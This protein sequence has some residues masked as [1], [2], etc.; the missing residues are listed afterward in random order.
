MSAHLRRARPVHRKAAGKGVPFA[1]RRMFLKLAT[2]LGGGIA[3]GGSLLSLAAG[4]TAPPASLAA[5]PRTR[6]IVR[7]FADPLLELTRLLRQA[8]E[9]EHALLL[10]YSYAAF[11]VKP[12]YELIAG[13]GAPNATD[14]LGVAVQEMQ[15][16]AIVNRLLVEIGSS[17]NLA[18]LEFPF[19]PDV[20]PFGF[21][22]E[23]LSRRSLAKYVFCEAPVGFFDRDDV[24]RDFAAS[25]R[26]SL[27]PR[28]PPNH[29]GSLYDAVIEA[30][31]EFG[32][33]ASSAPDMAPWIET[34][35]Q[36]KREGEEDHFRFFQSLFL[37]TH[38]GF[39]GRPDVWR[40]PSSDPA[41]P[42]FPVPSNPTAYVGHENEIENPRALALAWLANLQ[43]WAVL[44]LLDQFFRTRRTLYRDLAVL[45]MMGAVA[46]LGRHLP[47][48]GGALPFDPANVGH[49]AV[50]EAETVR[51]VEALLRESQRATEGLEAHLPGDYPIN[52]NR[53]SLASLQDLGR[54]LPLRA[55]G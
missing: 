11:S 35:R 36:V 30:A 53:E 24:D 10:Q 22:L 34:L 3:G 16:L 38:P 54:T 43:Y 15:H 13:G 8:A 33:A 47:M 49:S 18:P 14:L 44:L 40:L 1:D 51:Y 45:H 52:L 55:P 41:Y 48:L 26:A 32:H 46:S 37:G 31:E 42:V 2:A 20:Y 25:V 7:D 12:Q 50:A 23:P 19:E 5:A 39:G 21:Q 6:K 9:I 28:R 29:V 17:P 27:G 4:A